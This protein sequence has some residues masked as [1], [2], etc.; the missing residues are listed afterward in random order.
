M[1][2]LETIKN[3][4]MEHVDDIL[5][6]EVKAAGVELL[7][8]EVLPQLVEL[9]EH[10]TKELTKQAEAEQGWC[11]FRD[12]YF[13]PLLMRGIIYFAGKML[14][15]MQAAATVEAQEGSDAPAAQPG[16]A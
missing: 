2:D 14:D 5:T 16:Q 9:K 3:D 13:F 7:R 15:K 12:A 8:N 10:F 11:R 4:I 6:P 1:P